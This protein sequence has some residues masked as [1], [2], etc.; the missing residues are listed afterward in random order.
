M[1]TSTAQLIVLTMLVA[2]A[3]SARSPLEPEALPSWLTTLTRQLETEP[4][5]DPP[6]FVAR[7]DYKGQVVYYLPSR[8]CDVFSNLYRADGAIMCHPDGGL[9]GRGD[10]RCADFLAERKNEQIV[11]RDPR[12]AR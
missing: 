3:C 6:A 5:A 7:Y 1:R 2:V 4:V 8:C 10:G 11:W 12:G 9:S